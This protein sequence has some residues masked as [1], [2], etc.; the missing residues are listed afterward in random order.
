MTAKE[1]A[2]IGPTFADF[3]GYINQEDYMFLLTVLTT[4]KRNFEIAFRMFDLDGNGVVD[5]AEFDKV[6]EIIMK[7]TPVAKKHSKHSRKQSNIARYFFGDDRKNELTAKEFLAFQYNIQSEILKM[8]FDKLNPDSA[9]TI[10]HEAFANMILLHSGFDKEKRGKVR[11]RIK[12]YF[13]KKRK[14]FNKRAKKEA[15]L[16]GAD[17]ETLEEYIQPR[18]S[19]DE[20][21]NFFQFITN[22][23][24]VDTAFAFYA[25][26]GKEVDS[27]KMHSVAKTVCGI[28]LSENTI[29]LI[30]TIF[31]DDDSKTLNRSEFVDVMKARLERGLKNKRDLGFTNKLTAIA[32]CTC[33]TYLPKDV[34]KA[35]VDLEELFSKSSPN[36]NKW[37]RTGFNSL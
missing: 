11:R 23:H 9:N 36:Q 8:E 1:L 14:Q 12:K 24:D 37:F 7:G 4:P 20:I 22:I 26:S 6:I 27:T 35:F 19:F 33:E 18:C 25:M 30:F 29:D 5:A 10:T 34:Y 13:K 2:K 21:S 16:N 28:E 32:S 17:L 3:G 31:D 15:E